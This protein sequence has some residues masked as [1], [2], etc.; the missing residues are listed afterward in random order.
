[1]NCRRP[2]LHL[3]RIGPCPV[4]FATLLMLRAPL[5]PLAPPIAEK[6]RMLL[7]PSGGYLGASL[8][9]LFGVCPHGSLKRLRSFWILCV[10]PL[11]SPWAFLAIHVRGYV[12]TCGCSRGLLEGVCG[13]C[14]AL[15]LS[16]MEMT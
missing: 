5:D 12:L 13:V 11:K 3:A 1:M 16:D 8:L 4:L 14:Q 7:A 15:F 10:V 9:L 2:Y 6:A